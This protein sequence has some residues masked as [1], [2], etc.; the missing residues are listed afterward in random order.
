M[1]VCVILTANINEDPRHEKEEEGENGASLDL[2]KVLDGC[3]RKTVLV[4]DYHVAL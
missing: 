1:C 3:G 2:Q 4:N